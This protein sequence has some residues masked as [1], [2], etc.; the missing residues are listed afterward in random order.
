MARHHIVASVFR[1]SKS[2]PGHGRTYTNI[3]ELTPR[4]FKAAAGISLS[5]GWAGRIG[6]HSL[7]DDDT[8]RFYRQVWGMTGLPLHDE[9]YHVGSSIRVPIYFA[10]SSFLR[11]T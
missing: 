9:L 4:P 1:V 10:K 6:L 2:L 8:L 7:E 3:G 11:S 5:S